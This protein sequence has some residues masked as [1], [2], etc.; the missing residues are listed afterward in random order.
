[1]RNT[2]L[3]VLSFI[4]LTLTN[5][6]SAQEDKTNSSATETVAT[7]NKIMK[8][9]KEWKEKLTPEQY[10]ITREKG[11]ERA[12]TGEY[13]NF[14]EEGIYKCVCC[15]NPLFES[16]TKFKSGSGW[17][18]FFKPIGNENIEEHKDEGFGMIRVEVTCSKCDAHLGHV[19]NDGPNPTGNRYC[20]NSAS[21]K[22]DEGKE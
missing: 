18:S 10:K 2:I 4:L 13:D 14:Y 9:E 8:T 11:T 3:L 22:F 17:P 15:G 20:I 16:D 7:T 12:F 6:C 21:L 1:M 19:F 5:S